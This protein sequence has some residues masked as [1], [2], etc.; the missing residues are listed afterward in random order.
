MSHLQRERVRDVITS[1]PLIINSLLPDDQHRSSPS[2]KSQ[3]FP[4]KYMTGGHV[5]CRFNGTLESCFTA[6]RISGGP[7]VLRRVEIRREAH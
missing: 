4:S 1:K 6:E 3:Y 2:A 7:E 5:C